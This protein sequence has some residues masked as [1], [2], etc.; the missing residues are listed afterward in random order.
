[1]PIIP[2]SDL[3]AMTGRDTKALTTSF[4]RSEALAF[5]GY[6]FR[7]LEGGLV[8]AQGKPTT[9]RKRG[10][11]EIYIDPHGPYLVDT[12][13]RTCTCPAFA[14][15]GG[16]CH[17]PYA[18][19]WLE[20]WEKGESMTVHLVSLSKSPIAFREVD[21]SRYHCEGGRIV[22]FRDWSAAGAY[23]ATNEDINLVT[24]PVE[25]RS[26]DLEELAATGKYAGLALQTSEGVQPI[27]LPE[28]DWKA[29]GQIGGFAKR[30]DFD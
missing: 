26:I 25:L 13:A 27:P 4:A 12:K 16:C 14:N 22:V 24:K 9:H 6:K 17:L 7:R 15:R 1:M 21:G 29:R 28:V 30:E 20:S 3:T 18:L 19:R 5:Q 11:N 10:T 23:W 8:E 2:Y